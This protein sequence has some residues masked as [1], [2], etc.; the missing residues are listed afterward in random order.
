[1][2]KN[3]KEEE[4]DTHYQPREGRLSHLLQSNRSGI[5]TIPNGVQPQV[6]P[7]MHNQMDEE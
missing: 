2:G 3:E 6:P 4:D 1:V 5:K 7:S